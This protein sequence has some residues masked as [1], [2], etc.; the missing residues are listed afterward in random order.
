MSADAH[1]LLDAALRY[2]QLGYKVH[3]VRRA[4]KEKRPLL[5][6]GVHDAT[7]DPD[8]IDYYWRVR[9]PGASIGLSLDGLVAVDIDPRHGGDVDMLPHK[10]RETCTAKTGGGWHFLYRATN[11]VRYPGKL[12]PGVDCKSGP[13]AYI[14]VEPSLHASGAT[15]SW[16][17]ESEP[18]E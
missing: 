1:D 3:P 17:D 15:Y 18:W 7:T 16:V 2:A 14:V 9:Y 13:G 6:H 4:D 8:E 12:A 10:L 5:P 11:G